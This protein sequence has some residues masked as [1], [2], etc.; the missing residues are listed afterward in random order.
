MNVFE[1]FA[2]LGLDSSE[3]EDGLGRARGMLST[4]GG[5]IAR[6]LGALGAASGAALGAAA[7]GVVN[8]TRQSVN[9]FANYEQLAGGIETLYG[10]AASS[11]MEFA[12]QAATTTGQSMN[13]FMDAAIATSAAMI[14]S[15]E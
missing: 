2:K 6:G 11:M 10:D 12:S 1:L 3:Y 5:G 9:A 15:V 8:L 14:S 13:D 7:T 4:V